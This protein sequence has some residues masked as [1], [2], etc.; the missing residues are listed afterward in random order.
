MC[1][2]RASLRR[3]PR[4]GALP[5]SLR[6]GLS[7][8]PNYSIVKETLPYISTR[9]LTDPNPRTAGALNTFVYGDAKDDERTRVLDA[10]R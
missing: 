7:I 3:R 9:I 2:S 8:D 5:A 4:D 6:A 10:K 1:S